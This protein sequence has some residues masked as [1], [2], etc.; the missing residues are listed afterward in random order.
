VGQLLRLWVD[1]ERP[2]PEG[3]FHVKTARDAIDVLSTQEVHELSLDHDLGHC[4]KCVGCKGYKSKC[5]CQCHWSGYSVALFMST[6]GRWPE[7]KPTCH[8]ANPAGKA[9]IEATIH[10][11]FGQK[12][13][14]STGEF[15]LTWKELEISKRFTTRHVIRHRKEKK[16]AIGGRF[17]YSFTPTSLGEIAAI[18]CACGKKKTLTDFSDW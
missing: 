11:Y 18:R 9:N 10:R 17:T 14:A 8:S 3:W 15:R 7:K 2:A 1:D 4:E 13:A 16:T 6:T 12:L 5:G